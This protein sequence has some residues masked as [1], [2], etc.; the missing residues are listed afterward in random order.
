MKLRLLMSRCR[1]NST[2]DKVMSKKWI[3]LEKNSTDR[4]WALTEGKRS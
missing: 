4:V 3:Y 1:E 2:R